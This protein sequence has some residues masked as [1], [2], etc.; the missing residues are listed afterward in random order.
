MTTAPQWSPV[1]TDTAD[2]LTLLAD[3]KGDFA[4]ERLAPGTWAGKARAPGYVTEAFS[5]AIPHRGELRGVRIDLMPVR[6]RVFQ[7]YRDVAWGLL[8][9]PQLWGIWTPREI[10]DHVRGRRPAGALGALTDFVEETYFSP[11]VPDEAILADASSRA[12]AAMVER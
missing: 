8:P 4:V 11:R 5:V 1:D 3:D 6:E 12:R 9:G 2:L 10:F 7:I